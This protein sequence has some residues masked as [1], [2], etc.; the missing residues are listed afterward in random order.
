L[1]D[2]LKKYQEKP[3]EPALLE[4]CREVVRTLCPFRK[5]KDLYQ[6]IRVRK[7]P[8]Y[9]MNP[10]K[11]SCEYVYRLKWYNLNFIPQ[12]FFIHNK[13]PVL[14]GD[15]IIELDFDNIHPPL[16]YPKI[17]PHCW[18]LF[19]KRV[20]K[21]WILLFYFYFENWD[22]RTL[23]CKLNQKLIN[24]VIVMSRIFHFNSWVLTVFQHNLM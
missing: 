9:S 12:F 3:R 16:Y 2:I 23:S 21:R 20:S 13:A 18:K 6:S 10:I 19:H 15:D 14:K 7:K 5:A 17:L 24:L 1:Q 4:V 8:S 11:V 22:K